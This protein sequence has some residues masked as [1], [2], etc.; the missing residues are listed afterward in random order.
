MFL[1][2]E[3]QTL[4]VAK[5]NI[6]FEK[7]QQQKMELALAEKKELW[8]LWDRLDTLDIVKYIQE[9]GFGQRNLDSLKNIQ[10]WTL[11]IKLN[12]DKSGQRERSQG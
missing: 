12:S 4:K 2:Q 1:T 5:K 11:I 8:L 6:Y 9:A 10:P 3:V 7:Q